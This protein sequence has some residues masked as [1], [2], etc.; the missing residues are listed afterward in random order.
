MRKHSITNNP[1]PEIPPELCLVLA[2]AVGNTPKIQSLL[3]QSINWD[4]V[5]KQAVY[6]QVYPLVYKS[7][8]QLTNSVVPENSLNFLRGKYK[9]NAVHALYMAVETGRLAKCFEGHGIHAVVLKGAPL[10]W[11]LYGEVTLRPS[12]DID[13]LVAPDELKRVQDILVS[14]GYSST[15]PDVNMTD[16]QLKIFFKLNHGRHFDYWNCTK[17][18]QVE[19]HWKIG[20]GL[21][22]PMK[23]SIKTISVFGCSIPVLPKDEWFSFLV[24]HGAGHAWFRLRWLVDI[25]MYMKQEDIDWENISHL[26]ECAGKQSF[27]HQ[28]LILVN[29]L[30]DVPVPP[31]FQS[32]L[33]YDQLAWKLASMAMNV[34]LATA[35]E[36]IEG[37]TDNHISVKKYW[38]IYD[39]RFRTGW[40]NKMLYYL[41]NFNPHVE[42][43]KSIA[44]PDGL[45]PLYYVIRPFTWFGRY[46]RKLGR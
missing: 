43:I 42:D 32:V 41:H 26:A 4:I 28:T 12:K 10:A 20:Y 33:T 1:F 37:S 46:V 9:E 19:I 17:N 24:F 7:L 16:R 8:S 30:L 39:A 15:S 22:M 36:V 40:K 35:D 11:R 23:S 14:E 31:F 21:S 27:L 3:K 29:R 45:F 44:L 18:I 13:I 38:K 25:A 34:S 5:L 6:H 2:S